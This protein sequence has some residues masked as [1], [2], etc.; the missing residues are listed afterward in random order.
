MVRFVLATREAREH[1]HVEW[2]RCMAILSAGMILVDD[3]SDEGEIDEGYY[4]W[5]GPR[6]NIKVHYYICVCN[7]FRG[8]DAR[9]SQ[10]WTKKETI[11]SVTDIANMIESGRLRIVKPEEVPPELVLDR[12]GHS[13]LYNVR[14]YEINGMAVWVGRQQSTNE[15]MVLDV[16]GCFVCPT[17]KECALALF[18]G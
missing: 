6:R 15:L 7:R 16:S 18:A 10:V 5:R 11:G 8:N 14:C 13:Q 12:I 4:N 17:V 2:K 3:N 1:R 9:Y